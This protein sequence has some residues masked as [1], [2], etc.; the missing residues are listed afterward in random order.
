MA[1]EQPI[2][3]KTPISPLETDLNTPSKK[4]DHFPPFLDLNKL[5]KVGYPKYRTPIIH[6]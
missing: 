5:L 3:E 2:N 4:L 6:L 1:L